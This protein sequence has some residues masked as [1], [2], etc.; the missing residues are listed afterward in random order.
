VAGALSSGST[1]VGAVTTTWT[2]QREGSQYAAPTVAAAMEEL[3][4]RGYVAHPFRSR[5]YLDSDGCRRD[6][7]TDRAGLDRAVE[8]AERVQRTGPDRLAPYLFPYGLDSCSPDLLRAAKGEAD[9]LGIH[10]LT[11]FAQSLDEIEGVRERHGTSPVRYLDDL[12]VLD[13]NLV[14]AHGGYAAGEEGT[15][16]PDGAE[17][18]L[19]ADR[20][21]AVAHDPLAAAR[22]GV[23]LD[24]F[25]RYQNHGVTTSIG[26]GT[27]PQDV[28]SL[29]RWGAASGKA[30]ERR[31]DTATARELFDAATLG[32]A[33]ALGRPDIGKL[34][35]GARADVVCIDFSRSHVGYVTDPI[36]TL[37]YN[38]YGTDVD[39]VVV[40]GDTQVAD[41][42]PV[43][44][45][46]E[47]LAEDAQTAFDEAGTA[48]A[49]RDDAA[50]TTA[51]PFGRS[52]RHADPDDGG[53]DG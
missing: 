14:L 37:L 41:G 7:E 53:G 21:V 1:T 46:S 5:G 45:D 34:A 47:T 6:D 17:L 12:G 39:R 16:T 3:G 32:G 9:R 23:F 11:R 20:E 29:L 43:G 25:S 28:V 22:R 49:E 48:L 42:S 10:L 15:P 52:F 44:V 40:G 31:A 26:T 30:V 51:D 18:D 13:R 27:F 4:V 24:S 36:R 33:R 19:L 2:N 50:D 35:P 8:F 38:C